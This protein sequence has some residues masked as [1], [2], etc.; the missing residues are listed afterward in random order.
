ME[1]SLLDHKASTSQH[2][3]VGQRWGVNDP[4]HKDDLV[5]YVLKRVNKERWVSKGIKV[6]LEIRLHNITN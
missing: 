5:P 6:C 4:K 2:L 1:A 3:T